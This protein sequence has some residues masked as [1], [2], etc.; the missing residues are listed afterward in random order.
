MIS[1]L[2]SQILIQAIRGDLNRL[3][4]TGNTQYA[5]YAIQ[6]LVTITE[7]ESRKWTPNTEKDH[8]LESN[9]EPYQE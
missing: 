7:L 2:E 5:Y 8:A 3:E 4:D 9:Q 6:K 1:T